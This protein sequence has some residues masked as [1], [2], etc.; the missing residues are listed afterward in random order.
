M[1]KSFDQYLINIG[2]KYREIWLSSSTNQL[3]AIKTWYGFL[4]IF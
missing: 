3:C 1:L 4:V 2:W